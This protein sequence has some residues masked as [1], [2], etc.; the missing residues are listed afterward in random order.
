MLEIEVQGAI[1]VMEK[2][3]DAV[4]VFIAPPDK[5]AL[6]KRLKARGSESEE[7]ISKRVKAA[8]WE[9]EQKE[10]YRYVV[11]NDDLNTTVAKVE[12]IMK[13]EKEKM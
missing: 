6:Y 7:E 4:S 10:K 3:P 8:E 9:L 11:V 12:A 1:K 5:E 13:N 2:C